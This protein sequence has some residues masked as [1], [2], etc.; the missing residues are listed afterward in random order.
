V[1]SPSDFAFA[2]SN[3][4]AKASQLSRR[5]EDQAAQAK[6]RKLNTLDAQ[7]GIT[8]NN[9]A[10]LEHFHDEQINHHKNEAQTWKER[11]ATAAR[12]FLLHTGKEDLDYQREHKE[13]FD[14]AHRYGLVVDKPLDDDCPCDGDEDTGSD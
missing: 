12:G 14:S 5:H 2:L 8:E 11:A 3:Y 1:F 4:S 7:F 6:E 9:R 10:R 13:L